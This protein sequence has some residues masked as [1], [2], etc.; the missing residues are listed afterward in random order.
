M[1]IGNF[2]E[3]MDRETLFEQI[4]NALRESEEGLAAAGCTGDTLQQEKLISAFLAG[5]QCMLTQYH[6]WLVPQLRNG[7]PFSYN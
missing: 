7:Q 1:D 3:N 5:M 6:E 2:Y 4:H